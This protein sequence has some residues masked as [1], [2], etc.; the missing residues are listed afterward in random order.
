MLGVTLHGFVAL[1]LAAVPGEGIQEVS[2]SPL[3]IIWDFHI[4]PDNGHVTD[5]LAERGWCWAI[6]VPPTAARELVLPLRDLGF[7]VVGQIHAHPATREWHWSRR[8]AAV[9]DIQDF[10]SLLQEANTTPPNIQFFMEDDSAGVGFS[11]EFLRT[12]PKTH[13]EAMGMFDAYLATAMEEATKFPD[14]RRWAMA[15]FAGTSH[16]YARHGAE[17][18]IVERA[19]DDI[20]DLQTAIAFARG[21][22]RQF[23]CEWGIDLSLWWGV[24]YGCV[25]DFSPSLYTRHLWLSYISG[26]QMFR[27]EGG[28]LLVRPEGPTT[29]ARAI[30]AFALVAKKIPPGNADV[31]VGV[32]LPKDHGWMTPAYWRTTNEAWNYARIPYRQ[33]D[34]GIDGFFK[35][36]FPGA[37]YAQDPFPLGAYSVNEP[38][39]S[40]FALSCVTPEFAPSPDKVYVAEPPIPFG[41]YKNRDQARNDFIEKNLDPSPYRPMGDS[42]WGEIF[43]VITD[44]ANLETLKNYKTVVLLGQISL[45]DGLENHLRNYVQAGGTVILSVGTVHPKNQ[46][47]CGF[48]FLPELR[49]GRGWQYAGE[50]TVHEPFR[51]CPLESDV[52]LDALS[53]PV[54]A[55]NGDP[56]VVRH[57]LGSGHVYTSLIPWFEGGNANIAGPVLKVLD[58]HI[59]EIQPVHVEGPPAAWVSSTGDDSSPHR[60]VVIANHADT[61]WQGKIAVANVPDS[62]HTCR[63]V[64]SGAVL[65][66]DLVEG[67]AVAEITIPPYSVR[68]LRW[69]NEP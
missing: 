29:V 45:S 18:I 22:A 8:G 50:K 26:A 36:A 39:A 62:L 57:S 40:P 35:H 48:S 32:M 14:V 42:R 44:D 66:F 28:D 16:H 6:E 37:I 49:V 61:D 65:P 47:L 53:V 30:E 67:C 64:V 38:P 21:A 43:D 19:N 15:G 3:R 58:K 55:L 51:Y 24:I 68:V 63:D 52:N 2:H 12:P 23:G 56:L 54:R 59:F 20:E 27:I 10:V 11:A 5:W 33:G 7:A 4:S 69:Q 9:P 34:R 1:L 13:E 46:G 31:P 25:Q 17:G 41:T 60:T